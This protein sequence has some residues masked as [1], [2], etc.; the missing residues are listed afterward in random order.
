[1]SA[2]KQTYVVSA[3]MNEDLSFV[4]S[5]YIGCNLEDSDILKD[6]PS[7]TTDSVGSYIFQNDGTTQFLNC[8]GSNKS[9]FEFLGVSDSEETKSFCVIDENGIKVNGAYIGQTGPAGVTGATGPQGDIGATGA[10]GETGATGTTGQQGDT[11]PQGA[12]GATGPQG[13]TGPTLSIL[14]SPVPFG[15]HVLLGNGNDVYDNAI[16]TYANGG[17]KGYFTTS[18][19]IVVDNLGKSTSV[20]NDQI[21]IQ[22][23]G[24]IAVLSAGQ[25]TFNGEPA[26][27]ATGPQGDIGATGPTGE[28]GSSGDIGATGPTGSQGDTGATGATGT[29][30]GTLDQNLNANN[31]DI[32]NVKNLGITGSFST[33]NT[34]STVLLENG[35]MTFN[36]ITNGTQ[37]IINPNGG[38]SIGDGIHTSRLRPP[39]DNIPNYNRFCTGN[40]VNSV[41]YLQ[42]ADNNP[43]IQLSNTPENIYS[44][45]DLTSLY[46][47][48]G[49]IETAKLNATAGTLTLYDGTNT[50][51]LSTSNLTFN[52]VNSLQELKI[53]QTNTSFQNISA[54]IYADGRPP[55]APTTTIAQQYGYT[56]S[57]YFKNTVAGYK[58]NW[59][60]G[61]YD[62]MTV[63]DFLGLYM[64]MFNGITITNDDTPFFVINTTV[65]SKRTYIFDQSVTPIANT[66]YC[67]FANLSGD[68]PAPDYYAQT[69]NNM[70]LSTVAGTNVGPFAPTEVILYF[71]IHS[72]SSSVVN[73]VEFAVSKLG[74]MTPNGTKEVAYIPL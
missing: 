54:L 49:T 20:E 7:G 73:S 29:F 57:W 14:T 58:I 22:S 43:E 67:M 38:I 37:T 62:G 33:T 69:L 50:S 13:A 19:N 40:G 42:V 53:K 28:T 63:A 3:T 46:Y 32:T 15:S 39:T 41:M 52:G 51:I 56:P 59:Y 27:G 5:N 26:T 25:L 21:V 11:G 18:N 10:K 2:K 6:I 60:A 74:I 30:S 64:Y 71:S 17:K 24:N 72:N 4:S 61:P 70:T 44:R 12:T 35:Q 66:R 65:G 55:A 34:S 36:S 48:N 45:H 1:M 31:F 68:C 23:N 16:I 8:G 9:Q 47:N